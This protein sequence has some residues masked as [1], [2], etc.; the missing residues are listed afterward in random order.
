MTE[1]DVANAAKAYAF[2]ER[3]RKA[4]DTQNFDYA[5]EMYLDGLRYDPDALEQGHLKLYELGLKRQGKDGKKP[6]MMERMKH[7]RGKTPLEQMLNAEYLLAKDPDHLPYAEAMLK[8]AVAGGYRRTV[9]WIANL[10][11]QANNLSSRPSAS[12]YVLLKDS[13]KAI[14]QYDKA[15]VACQLASKLRPQ[16][17]DLADEFKNLTAELTMARGK[18]DQEGDFRQSIKDREEQEKLQSQ[19]AVVKTEDY[20]Q[21]AVDEARAAYTQ[22]PNLPKNIFGLADALS[23][24]QESKA[25]NEAIELLEK[26]Y[27][28]KKDFS[29]KQ[30]AGLIRMK[31]LRRKIRRAKAVVE[32]KSDD[33]EAKARLSQLNARLNSVELEHYGLCVENYPTDLQAKFEYGG[34]LIRNRKFDDAIPLFQ[35]AQ[36]DPRHKISSMDK[37]GLCFFYKGWY[38]DAIDIFIQA[39]DAYEIKDD[40]VAKDL[41]YNLARSYEQKGDAEKAL[42]IYRKIA[43]LDFAYRDVRRRVDK[44]RSKGAGPGPQ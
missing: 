7:M 42:E 44:L 26:A 24:M 33:A 23:E 28:T 36:K 21:S 41:R 35:E 43:Q 27:K 11:F 29:Y 12:T 4:A 38:A 17:A 34:R 40:G 18:Y 20:K 15:I 6:S 19:Q 2:F 22:D 8:A 30:R 5:I 32:A 3:A 25:D 10:V 1:K 39:I 13:Y 37:I 16:D 14:G 31:Q 9:G